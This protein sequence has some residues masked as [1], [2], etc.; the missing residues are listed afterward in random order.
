M[1]VIEELDECL[2]SDEHGLR[3]IYDIRENQVKI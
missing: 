3:S 2:V 1:V